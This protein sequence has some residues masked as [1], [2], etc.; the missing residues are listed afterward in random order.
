Y[1]IYR[2]RIDVW[3]NYYTVYPKYILY[4]VCVSVAEMLK[5]L[6]LESNKKDNLFSI[7]KGIASS[8]KKRSIK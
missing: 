5:I 7:F 8:F 2:N 6:V 4:E 1:H 3:K